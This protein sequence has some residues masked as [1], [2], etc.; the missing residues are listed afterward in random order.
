MEHEQPPPPT[1]V[2]S[3]YQDLESR[4]KQAIERRTKQRDDYKARYRAAATQLTKYKLS[5]GGFPQLYDSYVTGRVESLRNKIWMFSLHHYE[6]EKGVTTRGRETQPNHV[7]VEHTKPNLP[8]DITPQR[9]LESANWR[10]MIIE[11]FLW[12]Y[13]VFRVFNRFWWAGKHGVHMGNVYAVM[14]KN[15]STAAELQSFQMWSATTTRLIRGSIS[16]GD[17][18][19][20]ESCRKLLDDLVNEIHV[21]IKPYRFTEPGDM[22]NG[23]R[24]VLQTAIELDEELSQPLAH[25]RWEF[26]R[27][28]EEFDESRMKLAETEELDST[29]SIKII[30]CPGITKRGQAGNFD[31]VDWLVTAKVS[32][33]SPIAVSPLATHR[34]REAIPFKEQCMD[35]VNKLLEGVKTQGLYFSS[36]SP[37][38]HRK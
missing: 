26:P 35:K 4:Y 28:G 14:K 20:T 13:F 38:K 1:T 31:K 25:F 23:I 36:Q 12:K 34:A 11:S 6:E 15:Q 27:V 24:E 5:V 19:W 7:F 37:E 22:K 30:I 17:P 16:R 29:N 33:S 9:A 21:A 2:T 3:D 10:P 8:S 32:C 18:G